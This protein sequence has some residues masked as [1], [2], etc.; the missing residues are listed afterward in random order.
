MTRLFA[1]C[2]GAVRADAPKILVFVGRNAGVDH[3]YLGWIRL[4]ASWWDVFGSEL[5]RQSIDV[6][7]PDERQLDAFFASTDDHVAILERD[8]FVRLVPRTELENA[9][10]RQLVRPKQS[11]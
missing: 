9:L 2:F 3:A 7:W 5:R 1:L 8:R 10:L 4:R 11:G 6:A